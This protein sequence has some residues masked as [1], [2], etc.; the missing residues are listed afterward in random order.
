MGNTEQFERIAAHYDTP[1]RI[2]IARVITEAIKSNAGIT[3]GKTAIDF[4]CGTGLIGM[5]LH[6]QY[7]SMVFLDTST[8]MLQIVEDK[9]R[10]VD[11]KNAVTLCVEW[12]TADP[13]GLC[14][15]HIFAVQVPLHI[16]QIEPLLQR[17]YDALTPDGELFL[18]DFDKNEHVQSDLVNNGFD[19][20]ALKD[21]LGKIGFTDLHSWTFYEGIG[22][23]M[24]QDASLF[25]LHAKKPGTP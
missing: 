22:L 25:M 13:G 10:L 16:P 9:L 21:C 23:F 12:E 14:A 2:R 15:D 6:N 20:T 17:L 18:V 1:E 7:G 4:G 24:G 19:Q 5:D 8:Q 11:A 3:A